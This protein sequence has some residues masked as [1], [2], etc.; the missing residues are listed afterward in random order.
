MFTMV[1]N[2]FKVKISMK[3][4]LM[5]LSILLGLTGNLFAQTVIGEGLY[6][7]DLLNYIV[8]N[9]KTTSTL[10]YTNCRDI[11]YSEIDL[12]PGNQLSGIYTGFSITM[13]MGEDPSSYA[14][15][16]GINCEHSWPKSMGSE[17]E[18]QKSDMHHLYPCKDNVNSSRGNDPF[19]EISDIDADRWYRF[20]EVLYTVPGMYIDE[21]SEKENDGLDAFEP[22]ESVKGNIARS[23]FY[24]YAMY[25]AAANTA[26]WNLQKDVLLDWHYADPVDTDEDDRTWAIASYQDGKPNPFVIDSTLAGRIWFHLPAPDITNCYVQNNSVYIQWDSVAGATSYKVYSS[27]DPKTGFA[28]DTTGTLAGTSWHTAIVNQRKFYYVTA[29]K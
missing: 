24:F 14:Y 11:M 19:G 1:S 2:I 3:I 8:V 23:M 16:N 18:P 29:T 6:E 22:R 9:Y 25:Q 5:I 20:D 27:D 21:Y 15:Q 4:S 7:E 17:P 26:F 12:E 10:G 28:E 13:D